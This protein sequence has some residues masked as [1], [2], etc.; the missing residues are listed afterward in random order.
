M[1]KRKNRGDTE[2]AFDQNISFLA[3]LIQLISPY[4]EPGGE[5]GGAGVEMGYPCNVTRLAR[6]CSWKVKK[7]NRFPRALTIPRA[8]L[9]GIWWANPRN[10]W[11][12]EVCFCLIMIYDRLITAKAFRLDVLCVSPYPPTAFSLALQLGGRVRHLVSVRW[13]RCIICLI[14]GEHLP[15]FARLERRLWAQNGLIRFTSSLLRFSHTCL[16][17]EKISR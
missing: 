9:Q 5:G 7:G 15:A 17:L 13:L 14:A 12:Q 16:H 1:A 3:L 6:L 11:N 10:R 4:L 8:G 2:D